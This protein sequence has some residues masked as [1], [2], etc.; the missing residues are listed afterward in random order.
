MSGRYHARTAVGRAVNEIEE[1]L[2]AVFLGAMTVITFVNVVA[3]YVF[4]ANVLWA[5]EATVFLFAWLVLFGISYCVKI[6]AHLGVDALVNLFSP[7]VRR[8]LALLALAASLAYAVLV[9]KGS[10]DYWYRFASTASFLEVNDVPF[11]ASIQIALGLT[12]D[13]APLYDYLPRYIPYFILPFG[14]ALFL[15]RLLEAGW[16]IFTGRRTMLIASH[17]VEDMLEEAAA[18]RKES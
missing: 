2:I 8:M 16:E 11:P 17:E 5:L 6:T 10:W 12:E 15:F 7:G 9:L 1:T 18:S 13:G 3:R 4:N 14:M